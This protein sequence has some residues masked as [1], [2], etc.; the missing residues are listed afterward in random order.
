MT[1]APQPLARRLMRLEDELGVVLFERLPRGTR[2]TPAGHELVRRARM[3]LA[4]LDEAC[5][6][7]RNR[8]PSP[9][10]P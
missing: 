2:P 8:E 1:H 3:I 5:H 9:P 10:D 7:V 4:A 6:A